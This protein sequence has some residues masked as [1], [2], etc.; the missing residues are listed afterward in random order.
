MTAGVRGGSGDIHLI[1]QLGKVRYADHLRAG[2]IIEVIRTPD[3][4]C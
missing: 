4:A 2:I 1:F 3:P